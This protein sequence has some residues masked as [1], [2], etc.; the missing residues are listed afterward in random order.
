MTVSA[1]LTPEP[2]RRLW[3]ILESVRH[4]AEES[5][6]KLAALTAFAAVELALLASV[7]GFSV[8]E[9]ISLGLTL[10]LGVLGVSPLHRLPAFVGAFEGPKKRPSVDDSLVSPDDISKYAL[11][12]LIL[13]MDRYLGGGITSTQ[14]FEDIVAQILQYA[15]LAVRKRRVLGAACLLVGLAQLALLARLMGF[16]LP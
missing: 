5:D 11:G 10:P 12:D 7:G 2:E 15:R 16:R 13:R 9:S 3:L 14:Y 8:V 4:S 1:H 6:R